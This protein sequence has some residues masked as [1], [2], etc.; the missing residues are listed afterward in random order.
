MNNILL[1]CNSIFLIILIL[2]QNDSVK[3]SFTTQNSTSST[4]PFEIATWISFSLQL[5]IWLIK[6][7]TTDF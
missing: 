4:N 2:N 6:I 7:K 5:S 3:D 1:I